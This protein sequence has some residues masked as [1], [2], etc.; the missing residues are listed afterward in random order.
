MAIA[1]SSDSTAWSTPV[2]ITTDTPFQCQQGA[3]RVS[4]ATPASLDDGIVLQSGQMLILPAGIS[5]VWR[6]LSNI[7]CTVQYLEFGV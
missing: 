2:P 3:V 1:T 6:P 7:E 5:L 4:W